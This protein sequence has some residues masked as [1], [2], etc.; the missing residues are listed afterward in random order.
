MA[1]YFIAFKRSFQDIRKFLIGSVLFMVPFVNLVTSVFACGYIVRCAKTSMKNRFKLPEW[2]NWNA[3]FI[4]GLLASL[5]VLIYLLPVV[6]LAIFLGFSALLQFFSGE[7]NP[8]LSFLLLATLAVLAFT[9]YLT[10]VALLC[11]V[12]LE[13]F[14]AA[15]RFSLVLKKALKF[16]YLKAWLAC[17]LFSAIVGVAGL[18]IMDLL[19]DTIVGP[20]IIVGFLCFYVGVGVATILGSAYAESQV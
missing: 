13:V 12:D 10:P 5:I 4:K 15:F 8:P 1:D 19:R 18:L 7:S 20:F 9:A 16:S 6:I 11:Y 14:K 3:L 17:V 2:R